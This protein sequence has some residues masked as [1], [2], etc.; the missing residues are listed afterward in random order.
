MSDNQSENSTNWDVKPLA[1]GDFEINNGVSRPAREILVFT[2]VN[3]QDRKYNY[4][5]GSS[6]SLLDVVSINVSKS[7]THRLNTKDGKKHIV[8]PG[9]KHIEFRAQQ[10]TF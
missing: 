1:N 4:P 2:T 9:W 5:D 10:W 7:G 6:V 8:A 3:E